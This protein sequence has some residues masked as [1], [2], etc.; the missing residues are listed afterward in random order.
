MRKSKGP[1]TTDSTENGTYHGVFTVTEKK[2]EKIVSI[3]L[4]NGMSEEEIKY[5]IDT[6]NGY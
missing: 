6:I 1:P 2:A 4:Y 5:V 3:P